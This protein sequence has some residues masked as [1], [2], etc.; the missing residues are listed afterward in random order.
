MANVAVVGAGLIGRLTALSL[1]RNGYR[2]TIFDKDNKQA[3]QSAAYAAAGLL[4]PLGESLH[5]TPNIVEMGIVSL[6]LWPQILAQLQHQVDFQQLGALMISH[7]QDFGE[8]QRLTRHLTRHYPQHDM[9][10]LN[11]SQLFQ[12]EPQL[13]Q[14]FTQGVYLPLEGQIDN[15]ML[16]TALKRELECK[17]INWHS[18]SIVTGLTNAL[19]HCALSA[20]GQLHKFDLVVDARGTGARTQESSQKAAP[21]TDLRGVRGELFHLLAPEVELTRPV[22]LMHPRYQLYIAPKANNIFVVGATELE[23]DCRKPITVRSSLE[24]LSAAYSVHSGFAEAHIQQH[25][26][27]LRPAFNDN[28]PQIRCKNRLI[29]VNGLYR[30]GYL[31]APVVVKQLETTVEHALKSRAPTSGESV[32]SN[33]SSLLPIRFC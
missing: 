18:E 22:R 20:N 10:K 31:I 1:V 11:Q 3:T 23:S 27:Q 33:Y 12:L 25:I 32:S 26:S 14:Q 19:D 4:T 17:L 7:Q 15:R 29:Q 9:H 21:L 28:Q 8:Y 30:H 16:L 13:S 5:C 24:L 2:V 6:N